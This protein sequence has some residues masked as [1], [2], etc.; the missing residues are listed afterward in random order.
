[1]GITCTRNVNR[2]GQYSRTV[3]LPSKLRIGKTATMA[4]DRLVL[5][6]PRGEID[7]EDLL[8]FLETYIEPNLWA[9]IKEK[10][11]GRVG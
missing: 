3:S 11:R 4:A 9:W 6:D 5:M 8:E 2:V 1:M 10:T 7:P